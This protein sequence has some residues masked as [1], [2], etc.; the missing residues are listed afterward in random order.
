MAEL[1]GEPQVYNC[2]ASFQYTTLRNSY[3]KQRKMLMVV[4]DLNNIINKLDL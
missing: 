1:E 2:G 4:E 3:K